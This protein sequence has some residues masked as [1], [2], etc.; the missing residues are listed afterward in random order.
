M[1]DLLKHFI[2]KD[3]K[4]KNLTATRI[5]P[6]YSPT[7]RSAQKIGTPTP[8]IIGKMPTPKPT[9]KKI[10]YPDN[11][12][13]LPLITPTTRIMPAPRPNLPT[14]PPKFQR[15]QPKQRPMVINETQ[16]PRNT[17]LR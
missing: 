13:T 1:K 5:Q 10:T 3:K 12:H 11:R 7:Q 8:S 14:T 2:K 15:F 9:P 17:L 16:K 6:N 4:S